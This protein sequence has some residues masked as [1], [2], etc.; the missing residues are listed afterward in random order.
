MLS[1]FGAMQ[2]SSIDIF[3]ELVCNKP[4]FRSLPNTSEYS[5]FEPLF[6]E[7]DLIQL[8]SEAL[9]LNLTD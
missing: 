4:F 1:Q 7:I 9:I 6:N 3:G 8:I 2:R 5:E